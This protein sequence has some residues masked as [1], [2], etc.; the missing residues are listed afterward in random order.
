MIR[1]HQFD[2]VE[3]VQI[4]APEHSVQALHDMTRHAEVILQKLQLPY[5]VL[6]LCTGDMGFAAARTHDLEVWLPAQQAY[7]EISSVSNCE[8][9]QAASHDGPVQDRTRAQRV[10]SYLEWFGPGGGAY[11]G[12]GAGKPPAGRWQPLGTRGAAALLGRAIGFAHLNL[13]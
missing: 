8:A 13:E 4:V 10:G 7:R 5:R 12:G 3:L 1:Q 11:T 6:A 2:K 9:F